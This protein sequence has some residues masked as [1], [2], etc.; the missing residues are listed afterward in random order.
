M[1]R[2][3]RTTAVGL[4]TLSFSLASIAETNIDPVVTDQ[5]TSIPVV[6]N[7]TTSQTAIPDTQINSGIDA[8]ITTTAP[9][10]IAAGFP[11]LE[12]ALIIATIVNFV[13][14]LFG[15]ILYFA[16]RRMQQFS[17][18]PQPLPMRGNH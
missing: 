1:D 7:N 15:L 3:T 18:V 17:P 9:G 16:K 5:K 2:F 6:I 10:S 11:S 4:L 12:R 13:V 8:A 14:I